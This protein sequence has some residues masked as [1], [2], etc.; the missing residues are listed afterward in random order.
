MFLTEAGFTVYTA[1]DAFAAARIMDR[2]AIDV[3]VADILL[4]EVN[5]TDLMLSIR[6]NNARIKVILITGE[7]NLDS[8]TIGLKAGA[9]DYLPKPIR[10]TDIIQ[11]VRNALFMNVLHDE[12][13]RLSDENLRYQQHLQSLVEEKT[14][15]LKFLSRRIIQVQEE[16]R[17]RISREIHDDLGQSLIALKLNLQSA[18][19]RMKEK[20]EPIGNDLLFILEYLDS[21]IQKSRKLSHALSPI[22]LEKLGLRLAIKELVETINPSGNIRVSLDLSALKPSNEEDREINLYRVVQEALNNI[23]RHSEATEIDITAQKTTSGIRLTIRDNGVGIPTSKMHDYKNPGGL[24]LL[25]MKKRVDLLGGYFNI[26]SEKGHG[27]EVQIDIPD[28]EL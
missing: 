17:S 20:S 18:I 6:N 2:I 1:T 28:T 10:K 24:G 19:G 11:S 3:V 8:C 22:A 5:G 26:L 25:I 15:E 12:N 9:F 4:P 27:T 14:E 7:P 16:E 21:I 13:R 23:V